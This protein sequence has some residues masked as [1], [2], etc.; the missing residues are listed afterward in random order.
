MLLRVYTAVWHFFGGVGGA[1]VNIF[2]KINFT[3][4]CIFT[5]VFIYLKKIHMAETKKK[6]YRN[7][8]NITY[9]TIYNNT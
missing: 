1:S 5:I 9:K 7:W 4:W 6:G 3:I 2:L 8:I